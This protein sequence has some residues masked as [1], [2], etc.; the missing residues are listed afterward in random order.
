MFPTD[1]PKQITTLLTGPANERAQ[2]FSPD[3]RWIAFNSN[4]S[5]RT[6]AYLRFRGDQT[7]PALGGHPLQISTGGGRVL[8]WRRDGK[9]LLLMTFDD[10]IAAVTV[11][12][13]GDSISAGQPTALFRLP[14][15]HGDVSVAPDAER[16]LIQE[17]PYRAGQTIRVLTNW[18]E[19]I[20]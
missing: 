5:G 4:R 13:R 1:D 3:G 19:R 18:H 11:D 6:E 2:T 20:K 7:P 10:Q 16:F 12:A 14:P 17:F 9:E 8:A 15:Y